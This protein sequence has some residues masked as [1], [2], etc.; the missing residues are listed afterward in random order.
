MEKIQS[1]IEKG[2][3]MSSMS[4]R[5]AIL[6]LEKS[7]SNINNNPKEEPRNIILDYHKYF[8][9]KKKHHEQQMSKEKLEYRKNL[10]QM[11]LKEY[12]PIKKSIYMDRKKN[13]NLLD[14]EDFQCSCHP[15]KFTQSEVDEILRSQYKD[16]TEDELFG[17]GKCINKIIFTECDEN[18]PCGVSCR[19]RKFQNHEYAE[20]YPIKTEDRGWG[21]CA[22]AFLPKDTF[23]MQYIGEIYSLDSEYGEKKMNEYKDKTCTYLMGLPNNNSKHEVIDPTKNG[24]MARFINHSCDPNCETRK[25]HVKGELCIG[26]FAKKDIQE[27]E[28]LTFNYDFDLNKTRYQKCLC[29]AK[30]CRGYLGISTEENKKK[31]NRNLNCSLCKEVCKHNESIIDCKTCGKFF[32]KKCAKKKGQLSSNN[33]YKCSHCLKKNI[34]SNDIFSKK[35]DIK[36][37]IKLDEEPIYDEIFEVGDEDLQKIKKNL[38]ELINIGACLFWDFQSENAILGTSNKI[39]LKISGTTKQIEGVKEAIKKLKLKKEEGANEYNVKLNVPKIYIRKIIGHQYRNLDSY[40][41]KFGVQ[42]LYD[43]T[44]ITDE[45]FSIQESTTIEIKGKESNVKAVVLSIKKYLYNLKVISIYLLQEDYF[46]LRQ[47]ICNLKTNVDPADLR[48]RKYDIKNEREIKHPFYYISNNIKDIVIIGF[49][50]EI[51]KAKNVIKNSILRQNNIAFNYSLSFLFPVYFKN[52]L[53]DFISEN[54]NE[55]D[56]NKIKIESMDP[57]YLRRHISITISG[58]WVAIVNIKTKLWNYLKNYA[59]DGVPKKHDINEFEQYAYNQEHKLISKS[60]RTYIIEQSPQIKNWDYISEDIEYL[61]QKFFD[62]KKL[63]MQGSP[64]KKKESQDVIENFIN[65]SD[66]EIRVN[67]LVNMRPGAYKK[68]FNMSQNDLF[69]DILGVLEETYASYKSSKLIQDNNSNN[70]NKNDEYYGHKEKNRNFKNSGETFTEPQKISSS[71][72]HSPNIDKNSEDRNKQNQKDD[73]EISN[74]KYIDKNNGINSNNNLSNN[75][76]FKKYSNN[77]VFSNNPLSSLSNDKK[78]NYTE[79]TKSSINTSKE[80]YSSNNNYYKNNN[81]ISSTYSQFKNNNMSNTNSFISPSNISSNLDNYKSNPKPY[82]IRQNYSNS[83][84]NL[85]NNYSRKD[86]DASS[87]SSFLNRKTNRVD[88]RSSSEGRKDNNYYHKKENRNYSDYEEKKYYKYYNKYDKDYDR[89]EK[90]EKKNSP[91]RDYYYDD[92][93]YNNHSNDYSIKYSD[94]DREFERDR[95]RRDRDRDRE[96]NSWQRSNSESPKNKYKVNYKNNLGNQRSSMGNRYSGNNNNDYIND[97]NIIYGKDSY[98]YNSHFKDS[99]KDYRYYSQINK[100]SNYSNRNYINNDNKNINYND[101]NRYSSKYNYENGYYKKRYFNDNKYIDK[102]KSGYKGISS[103]FSG[104]KYSDRQEKSRSRSRNS[105]SR[106]WGRSSH[107]RYRNREIIKR[108]HSNSNT[109]RKFNDNYE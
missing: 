96:R 74:N 86:N 16:K 31:L 7:G 102:R 49:E 105:R 8:V 95:D 92:S 62:K 107:S 99:Y 82:N 13:S 39:E 100:D 14:E 61:Q 22:G 90:K 97:N 84:Y 34:D 24:N 75:P 53:S 9:F 45:I 17:C 11:S 3:N 104:N 55:I 98:N 40:K 59:I 38:G 20:V 25:W 26:I 94:R 73:I 10:Y 83:N 41:S 32:H 106:S 89:Y 12:N 69:N 77:Q 42:I 33:E 65:T 67:Y 4:E 76:N 57:E 29:G 36:E 21:L 64:D 56:T 6:Y 54:K 81:N 52:K 109:V 70:E 15:N 2:H 51:E 35:D 5:Q 28:E 79:G 30:N 80:A 60:I 91:Y 50:N 43:T 1:K 87:N 63:I 93:S 23:I 103:N 18:C 58:R 27:D 47:N 44:L 37:K 71:I 48:L 46:Y 78:Q 85:S 108:E 88:S 101:N 68:V 72:F 66:K 19:N